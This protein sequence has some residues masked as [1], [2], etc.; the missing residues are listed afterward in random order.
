MESLSFVSVFTKLP[1]GHRDYST[2]FFK[3]WNII[4]EPSCEW[5]CV[6]SDEVTSDSSHSQDGE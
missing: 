2:H 1:N 6:T 4:H 5:E 3:D